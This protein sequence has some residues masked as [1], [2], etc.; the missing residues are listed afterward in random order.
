MTVT[1]DRD[2]F[3]PVCLDP[4]PP[5]PVSEMETIRKS[6]GSV[7]GFLGYHTRGS[8]YTS[9]SPLSAPVTGGPLDCWKK[10]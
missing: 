6:L 8:K 1:F 9:L 2:G 7:K 3:T 4:G 5:I 10:C